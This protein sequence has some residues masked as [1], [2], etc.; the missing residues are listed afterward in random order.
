MLRP[1]IAVTV[2]WIIAGALT[3]A[4][5][6]HI[7]ADHETLQAAVDAAE[8]GDVIVL[9]PG[10]YDG[11]I[12]IRQEKHG[13]AIRGDGSGEVTLRNGIEVHATDVT[14]SDLTLEGGEFGVRIGAGA[15]CT[16]RNVSFWYQDTGVSVHGGE[17]ILE[18]IKCTLCR[19]AGVVASGEDTILTVRGGLI[20]M[21][22]GPDAILIEDGA[23]ATLTDVAV[24]YNEE[25]GINVHTGAAV[26]MTDCVVEHN[27]EC[28]LRVEHAS[29]IAIDSRFGDARCGTWCNGDGAELVI[30]GGR[31]SNCHDGCVYRAA[32]SGSVTGA[33]VIGNYNGVNLTGVSILVADNWFHDNSY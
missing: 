1:W 5:T 28:G 9:A 32:A 19:T 24:K 4:A 29:V 7:P 27:P 26:E 8:S 22:S 25:N 3:E 2:F 33:L 16:I 23:T 10:D 20:A 18:D 14:V 31:I 13:I 17:A 6:L 30:E 15:S 12:L 21:T 11:P